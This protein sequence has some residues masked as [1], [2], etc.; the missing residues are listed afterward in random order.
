MRSIKSKEKNVKTNQIVISCLCSAMFPNQ[1]LYL[2]GQ[3][4]IEGES[5]GTTIRRRHEIS[6]Q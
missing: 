2:I 4:V 5:Y 1:S 3:L 6:Y